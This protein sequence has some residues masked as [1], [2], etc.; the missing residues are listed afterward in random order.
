MYL[1]AQLSTGWECRLPNDNLICVASQN[2][3]PHCTSTQPRV[4][5]KETDEKRPI[6]PLRCLEQ[7]NKYDVRSECVRPHT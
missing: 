1:V 5:M 7:V 2:H 6:D 4:A 3:S